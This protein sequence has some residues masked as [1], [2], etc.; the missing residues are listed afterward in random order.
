MV[1]ASGLRSIVTDYLSGAMCL[2]DFDD[3]F[4][5]KAW[6]IPVGERSER[7]E[8][9]AGV[10][11]RLSELQQGH[12][13]EDELRATLFHELGGFL[14]HCAPTSPYLLSASS[15]AVAHGFLTVEPG[16]RMEHGGDADFEVRSLRA[17]GTA[18]QWVSHR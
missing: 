16:W 11:L 8:L 12:W 17:P 18:H 14:V 2:P 5:T 4:T 3:C 7:A 10:V 6:S 1:T 9:A 15:V 13:T